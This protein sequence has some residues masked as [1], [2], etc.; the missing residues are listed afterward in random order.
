M[1]YGIKWWAY[2]HSNGSIQLKRHLD[3]QEF[4]EAAESPFCVKW[5]K[6]FE[7]DSRDKALEIAREM[8]K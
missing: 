1:K 8:L 3:N 5:T 4:V 6:A 7:A 2:L